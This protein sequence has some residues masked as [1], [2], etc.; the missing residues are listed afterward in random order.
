[1]HNI[2]IKTKV[3]TNRILFEIRDLTNRSMKYAGVVADIVRDILSDDKELDALLRVQWDEEH[4]KGVCPF[5]PE[6]LLELAPHGFNPGPIA[7]FVYGEVDLET[8]IQFCFQQTFNDAWAGDSWETG[9]GCDKLDFDLFQVT[10][11]DRTVDQWLATDKE[12]NPLCELCPECQEKVEKK[13]K[14]PDMK[15]VKN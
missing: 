7:R 12:G 3:I 9:A 14:K 4:Q 6:Q 11:G 15:V 5:T 2:Q 1:M 10:C 13:G 8:A